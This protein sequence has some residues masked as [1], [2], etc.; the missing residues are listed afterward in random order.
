MKKTSKTANV[1]KK[2]VSTKATAVETAVATKTEAPKAEAPKI[3]APKVDIVK[4][5]DSKELVEKTEEVKADTKAQAP[6]A[7]GQISF[8]KEEK[9]EEVKPAVKKTTDKKAAAPKSEAE[10]KEPAKK[11]V[12]KKAAPTVQTVLELPHKSYSE[13]DLVKIAT[14]VWVYDLGNKAEDIKD[15]ELYV[16]PVEKTVYYVINKDVKGSFGI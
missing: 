4:V 1:T 3:E 8:F 2:T 15:I 9:K 5:I 14:D 16:K 11:T 7:D 13:A 10:V 12:A 6:V